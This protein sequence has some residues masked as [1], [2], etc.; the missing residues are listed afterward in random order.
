MNMPDWSADLKSRLASLSLSPAREA[1]IIEE[2]S[3]HLDDRY[4][5]L[6]STGVGP[7][8]ARSSA[9]ADLRDHD[10]LASHLR[11]LRQARVREPIPPGA[12]SRRPLGD[13]WQDLGYAVRRLRGERGVMTAAVLTLALGIGANSAI[14]TVVNAVLLKPLPY[15]E[16]DRLAMIWLDNRRIGLKEDLTSY[17][18]YQDWKA[19]SPSFAAMAAFTSS[20]DASAALPTGSP[21]HGPMLSKV[22]PLLAARIEPLI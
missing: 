6:T 5:E 1:E 17:P 13:I 7:A 8:D 9:L 14:F 12:P 21:V 3:V 19:G 22:L 2:L 16:P 20:A 15:H 10:L 11:P 4:R 18:N